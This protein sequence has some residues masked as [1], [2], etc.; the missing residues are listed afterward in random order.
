MDLKRY[1]RY[2]VDSEDESRVGSD[3]DDEYMESDAE[4]KDEEE[5]DG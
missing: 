2:Q 4:E 1:D 5:L 3:D